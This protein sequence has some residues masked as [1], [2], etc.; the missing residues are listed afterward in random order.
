MSTRPAR[1]RSTVLFVT[2]ILVGS[3]VLAGPAPASTGVGGNAYYIAKPLCTTVKPGRASCFAMRLVRVAAG[4]RGARVVRP[5]LPDRAGGRVHP[6]RPGQGL[7][8]N[9]NATASS[10]LLVAIVDAFNNPNIRAD[11]N[12]FDTQYGIPAG[13]QHVVPRRQSDGRV[14]PA[15]QPMRAGGARRALDVQ[16]VRGL[17]HKC[18][19]VLVEGTSASFGDLAT[20]T[21]TAANT[22]HAKVISNS[23]GGSESAT[24]TRPSQRPTTTPASSSPP[25]PATTA[26]TTGTGSTPAAPRSTRWRSLRR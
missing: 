11:L 20:A 4:T 19:I 13:D 17:C 1:G 24:H 15:D 12:H 18:K 8:L 9:V 7:R 2:V 5:R 25:R 23:Y 21:N 22:V 6:G 14:E 3:A 10:G 16:T 26:G